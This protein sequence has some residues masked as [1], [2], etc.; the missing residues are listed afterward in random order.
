MKAVASKLEAGVGVLNM[1]VRADRFKG[2]S[3]SMQVLAEVPIA[4]KK[5][6]VVEQSAK[7]ILE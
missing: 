1:P 7:Y 3:M 2:M 5:A 4:S 6:T